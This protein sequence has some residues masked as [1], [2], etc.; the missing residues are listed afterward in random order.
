MALGDMSSQS[1]YET[2]RARR[3]SLVADAGGAPS[4]ERVQAVGYTA[5]LGC[6]WCVAVKCLD[7]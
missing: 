1:V 6:G 2:G 3:M 7:L 4:F 5:L